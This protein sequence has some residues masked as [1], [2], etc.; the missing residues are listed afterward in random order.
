MRQAGRV[1]AAA[2]SAMRGH[3]RPGIALSELDEC[4]GAVLAASGAEALFVGDRPGSAGQPFRGAVR[5]S[6]NDT[7][8]FGF[9]D[10]LCLR[11]GDVL[12]VE[13]GARVDGWCAS[14]AFSVG[15]SAIGEGNRV[16][17][18][19]AQ[20][21]LA[22]GIAAAWPGGRLGDV[23]H[24]VGLVGR[25]GGYGIP[26]PLGGYGI[27]R[28]SREAPFVPNEAAPGAGM[29]L[30]PG[31]VLAFGPIFVAGGEDSVDVDADGWTVRSGSGGCAVHV[32]HTVAVTDSGPWVLTAP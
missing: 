31:L 19:S 23:A 30:R 7:I 22:D 6:V 17:L 15:V 2:L 14:A 25:G 1:V 20:Q 24:A 8:A 5:A 27:G 28:A 21:A 9:P 10:G 32:A 3:V 16:L 26:G 18:E 29:P 12:S 13:C 4:A 11:A